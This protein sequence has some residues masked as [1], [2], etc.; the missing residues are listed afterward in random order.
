MTSKEIELFLGSPRVGVLATLGRDGYPHL[1]GMWFVPSG[2]VL[3]MWT[4]AKS[5]KALNARRDERGSLLIEDG[6]AY[7]ELIGIS[8]RGRLSVLDDFDDV[9]SIGVALFERYTKP[10]LDP[11]LEE[12][13]LVEID[14]QAQKRVGL[15]LHITDFA[16]WDHS[17]L[18]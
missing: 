14:R 3:R 17:K 7:N 10:D 18:S 16:S 4:Y 8:F 1:S 2:D 6:R 11:S 13:A 5:Q 12:I 15:E 9:R